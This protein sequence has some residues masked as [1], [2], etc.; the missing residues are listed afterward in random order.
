M[1]LNNNGFGFQQS[2]S[3]GGGTNTNIANTN[4]TADANRSFNIDGNTLDFDNGTAS[5][6]QI[7]TPNVIFGGGGEITS[8]DFRMGTSAPLLRL[9]EASGGGS[10][11][12]GITLGNL[13]AERTYTLPDATGTIALTSDIGANTN[14]A[15]T[16]LTA[17]GN[18]I[19]DA[20]SASLTFSSLSNVDF[21]GF[22]TATFN[23]NKLLLTNGASTPILA[24]QEPSGG[25][26]FAANIIVGNLTA[27]RI[28][29]LPNATGTIAL[30]SDVNSYTAG[31]GI[32]LNSLEFDLD[33]AQTIIT[34]ITNTSLVIGR[35]ADNDIDFA[36]DNQIK[37]RVQGADEFRMAANV[38]SPNASKGAALGSTTLQWSDL[39]LGSSGVINFNNGNC[40]L[41]NN[42]S[43]Q[44]TFA[45]ADAAKGV[46]IPSRNFP[47][48]GGTDGN[49]SSGDVLNIGTGS[50][51][52]GVCYYL[53]ADGSWANTDQRAVA[54]SIG[55]LAVAM[56]TGTASNVG[57]C[58]RGMVT[59]ATDIGSVGDVIYL[60]RN[61]EF[62]NAP[63]TSSGDTNRIMGY[64][65]NDS[66]GQIFFN[67]SQDWVT[68]A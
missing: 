36:T 22:T 10:F 54:S 55:F 51:T 21:S 39:F 11:F 18:R 23:G 48:S 45:T 49:V 57:M 56:G 29:T 26:T 61:G 14:L 5:I 53:R 33:A 25:G 8:V 37:F 60:Q 50:V 35:D 38:L 44:L 67:P 66:D 41:T 30:T 31:D 4:L 24:L 16:D 20:N 42:S 19:Y 52:A 6:L 27:E 28:L 59:M 65:L 68:V 3:G 9:F 64:C 58:I 12:G 32:T 47:P 7:K 1:A 62:D 34:S 17:T 40:T 63:S 13:S 15:N 46:I 43:G 2:S